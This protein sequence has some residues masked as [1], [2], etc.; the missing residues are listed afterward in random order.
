MDTPSTGQSV[1]IL[2]TTGKGNFIESDYVLPPLHDYEIRVKNVM[3]GVCRSD[4]DMMNGTFPLLPM[5]M[6]GHEGLGQVVE[7]GNGVGTYDCVIGDFVATRGEP[8]YADYYN[9]KPMTW[10]KVPEADPKYIIEPVA[11]GVNIETFCRDELVTKHHNEQRRMLIIGTGFLAK[12]FY[13][14]INTYDW[15]IDVWGNADS[16]YWGEHLVSEPNGAYDIIVDL[17]ETNQVLDVKLNDSPL[18]ILCSQKTEP[19]A[20]A[21][22]PNANVVILSITAP[23]TIEAA[24]HE[25]NRNAA[26][27][28]PLMWS[29]RFIAIK[30]LVAVYQVALNADSS[31]I[32]AAL[33]FIIEGAKPG[34]VGNAQYIHQPKKNH[35]IVTNGINIVFFINVCW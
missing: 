32:N 23:E 25:N 27:N 13:Q 14:T 31:V 24:V 5:Q 18:I 19:I 26:Q 34:P 11:C 35:V 28:T 2:T 6:H 3:T 30:S 21:K 7:V 4:I 29:L 22:I 20:I 33:S 1:K 12:V 8:A 15:D 16:K 10:V 17:K 9:C